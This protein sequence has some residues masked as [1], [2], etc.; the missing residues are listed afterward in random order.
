MEG[1][2]C[3][4]TVRVL[5]ITRRYVLNQQ[6]LLMATHLH[7]KRN[8]VDQGNNLSFSVSEGSKEQCY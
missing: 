2:W 8:E 1:K 3:A 7:R 6:S 5:V 4:P